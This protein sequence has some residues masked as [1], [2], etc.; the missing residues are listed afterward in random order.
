MLTVHE[1]AAIVPGEVTEQDFDPTQD[2]VR[3]Q[4][5]GHLRQLGLKCCVRLSSMSP[6]FPRAQQCIPIRSS[7][8]APG[9]I[10]SRPLDMR[11]MIC[12]CERGWSCFF[13]TE[14]EVR[15]AQVSCGLR[16][17]AE[18]EPLSRWMPICTL[19][20][21]STSSH[22]VTSVVNHALPTVGGPG[23]MRA[24]TMRVLR[25]LYRR[26]PPRDK[27]SGPSVT[28]PKELRTRFLP[29]YHP[30]KFRAISKRHESKI[31]RCKETDYAGT[32]DTTVASLLLRFLSSDEPRMSS[33]GWAKLIAHIAIV[34]IIPSQKSVSSQMR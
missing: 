27:V 12:I 5:N 30:N 16:C 13:R 22:Q 2:I 3:R 14:A 33:P 24:F 1:V 23:F 19:S 11:P 28:R 17:T 32:G 34:I 21:P 20:E 7:K 6:P 31:W 26:L 29:H 25:G 8:Q 4:R 9:M 10:G 18:L 15:W